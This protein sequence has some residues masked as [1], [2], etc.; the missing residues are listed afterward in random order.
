MRDCQ[1]ARWARPE[2][3]AIGARPCRQNDA[4]AN[5]IARQYGIAHLVSVRGEVE[6]KVLRF[7]PTYRPLVRDIVVR[8]A[9][10]Y[11]VSAWFRPSIETLVGGPQFAVGA[12]VPGWTEALQLMPV[13]SKFKLWIPGKLGY[14]EAGVPGAPI[15][16]NQP[17]VFDV[18]LLEIVKQ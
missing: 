1:E 3:R 16:P 10:V 7:K 5:A 4:Q 9:R 12:V 17:L 15:G 18:E 13:G 2:C 8:A 6:S 14:G 11:Y